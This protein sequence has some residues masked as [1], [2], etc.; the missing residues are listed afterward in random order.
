M[1]KILLMGNPN[2]G[3]S[4]IFSRLT[5]LDV[6]ASNYPGSTVEYTKG[7][8][9]ISGEKYE[10]VDVPGTYSLA[11]TN[12]AEEVAVRM[13]SEY[14]PGDLL[15]NVVDSANLERN[16][17]LT[18]E[19]LKLG[20]T[21]VVALNR[22]DMTASRGIEITPAELSKLLTVPVIPVTGVSGE[23][24]KELMAALEASA[25]SQA[26]PSVE[27]PESS[28][29]KWKFIGTI[30]TASQKLSHRHPSLFERIQEFSIR[31]PYAMLI[32][33]GVLAGSFAFIRFI[34]E[35][36]INYVLDP[37]FNKGYMPFLL[38]YAGSGSLP[39]WLSKF[40]LGVKPAPMESFGLLTTG[41][42]IP[43][44]VLLPYI[45]S[46][47][48]V[49][50]FLEDSGYLVRIAVV[51]DRVFHKVGLHGYASIP[52]LLGLGCKVPAIVST[53]I[54]ESE[55]EKIITLILI[56][57]LAPCMP[58]TAMIYAVLSNFGLLVVIAFF[59]SLITWGMIVGFVLNKLIKGETPELFVEIPPYQVPHA[60]T[61]FKKVYMRL[62]MFLLEAVPM[63][64]VGIAA[65]S[66]LDMTGLIEKISNLF[67]PVVHG[68]LGLPK[69]MSVVMMSGFL[70]KDISI[71]LLVP[72]NLSLKQL[73]IA[74][75]MLVIYLPC[76]ATF[77]MIVREFS[78]KTA[79]K[80]SALTFVIALSLA[81]L[82]NLIL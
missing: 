82:L 3:K 57:L 50:S 15:L 18:L 64:I 22:W 16:L 45:F 33:L 80:V 66:I 51:M 75:M 20:R 60:G 13:L 2:V 5:G 81:A 26:V 43:L 38:K 56:L 19:L 44:V 37:L 9:I 29:D 65:V 71:A 53:R 79:V 61:L 69:E 4:V 24:I 58:Q 35:S 36:L 42:Y 74:S 1:K 21:A 25:A 7:Y 34:G 72:F 23:G 48:F 27:V 73:I 55:K 68:L 32:A 30:T 52:I 11:A 39:A 6:I 14:G 31:M 47:Y 63:I 8:V 76:V 59:L 62:K 70:R 54:L 10:L 41:L 67:A 78:F 77:S 40:L 28:E 12:K 46:F 17:L 49:L